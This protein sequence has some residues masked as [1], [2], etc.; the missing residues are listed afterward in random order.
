M[1]SF[2][3]FPSLSHGGSLPLYIPPWVILFLYLLLICAFTRVYVP[4]KIFSGFSM[5]C[6]SQ[7]NIVQGS[8]HHKCDQES[9]CSGSSFFQDISEVPSSLDVHDTHLYHWRFLEGH[10]NRQNV[11]LIRIYRIRGDIPHRTI[12]PYALRS[13]G[14]RFETF[15]TIHSSS[16]C[17]V[18]S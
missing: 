12:L 16:D 9:S 1:F 13:L 4:S 14:P 5:S 18:L 6:G 11:Y 7:G 3:L 10:H 2:L 17:S 8:S 15:I